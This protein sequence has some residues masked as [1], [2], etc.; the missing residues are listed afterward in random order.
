MRPRSNVPSKKTKKTAKKRP[1]KPTHPLPLADFVQIAHS[2]LRRIAGSYF[3]NERPH[4]TLQP[5][6]LVNEVFMRLSLK[7]PETYVNR[8]Q[9]FAEAARAMRQKTEP[10]S[11]TF[12]GLS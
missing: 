9:F 4:H 6:A 2:E 12:P 10:D 5:T 7:G 8:A 1:S 11:H 3:Q